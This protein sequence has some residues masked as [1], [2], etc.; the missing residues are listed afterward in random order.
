MVFLSLKWGGNIYILQYN[1]NMFL[2]KDSFFISWVLKKTNFL[3][4][5]RQKICTKKS[6][7]QSTEF[8]VLEI[9][10]GDFFPENWDKLCIFICSNVWKHL[11]WENYYENET[12]FRKIFETQSFALSSQQLHKCII[13]D[14]CCIN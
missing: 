1:P 10:W 7:L 8:S 13:G 3:T 9:I 12:N 5:E 14:F 4:F 6:F 11:I 2:I